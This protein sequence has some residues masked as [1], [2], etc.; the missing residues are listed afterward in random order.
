ML[1]RSC[2]GP[3]VPVDLIS[4]TLTAQPER[5]HLCST[6]IGRAKKQTMHTSREV[7]G[8]KSEAPI[9]FRV[10][11]LLCLKKLCYPFACPLLTCSDRGA[12]R[13]R[14]RSGLGGAFAQQCGDAP[15]PEPACVPPR[16]GGSDGD[17]EF[18]QEPLRRFLERPS[19]R[20]GAD[21]RFHGPDG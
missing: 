2:R 1:R 21:G 13:E 16:G 14:F 12:G 9:F 6:T 19:K 10:K 17:N 20:K 11:I 8:T 5:P 3:A 18:R 15:R 7:E 4:L